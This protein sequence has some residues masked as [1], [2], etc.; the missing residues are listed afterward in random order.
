[1]YR[2]CARLMD[3][4]K[5]VGFVLKDDAGLR[6]EMVDARIVNIM[7][8][9]GQFDISCGKNGFRFNDRVRSIGDLPGVKLDRGSR[10]QGRSSRK[11][12][13]G[14]RKQGVDP[15]A[16]TSSKAPGLYAF[17]ADMDKNGNM[18]YFSYSSEYLKK[19]VES[20][21]TKKL[22]HRRIVDSILAYCSGTSKN[23]LLLSGLKG[24]GKTTAI[25]Q[26]IKYIEKYKETV[27]ISIHNMA[28]SDL[29]RL[30]FGKYVDKKYMFIDGITCIEDI[31]KKASFLKHLFNMPGRKVL[32]CGDD[33][34]ALS[35]IQ[36]ESL[37]GCEELLNMTFLDYKDSGKRL[38]QYISCESGYEHNPIYD[39]HSLQV[40]VS[41]VIISNISN[42]LNMN[43]NILKSIK[44][45]GIDYKKINGI[46][47]RLLYYIAY[48]NIAR[49]G[50]HMKITS[51]CDYMCE[52][53]N[54][55]INRLVQEQMYVREDLKICEY[56]AHLVLDMLMDMGIVDM[57][58][59][60]YNKNDSAYYITNP[61]L[62]N[63]ITKE[64]VA[65]IGI[66]KGKIDQQ[67][68][69]KIACG[70]TLENIVALHTL[71]AARRMYL[72]VS[73]YYGDSTTGVVVERRHEGMYG[74]AY[75]YYEVKM[76]PSINTKNL[77]WLSDELVN[78]RRGGLVQG[79][80]VLVGA[81]A[82]GRDIAES[83][84]EA[85]N[86]VPSGVSFVDIEEYLLNPIKFISEAMGIG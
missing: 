67:A 33:S 76:G 29:E 45:W 17:R 80:V 79:R 46:V 8:H 50:N 25:L 57:I 85:R 6:H 77:R 3:G 5:R 38:K 56:E 72:D 36:R 27:Y 14:S 81:K 24:A 43:R 48:Q 71:D 44:E 1:M 16:E 9:G 52:Q 63:Q 28:Y 73:I 86:G 31:V 84:D 34:L 49:S 2:A 4:K 23:V 59:G 62:S 60:A 39:A 13:M 65:N 21:V 78:G 19:Y 26:A 75:A 41:S 12:G 37:Y 82:Y 55:E 32:I 10:K 15:G 20:V 70:A 40:Y 22:Q 68:V 11:Q 53:G 51:V 83:R 54:K 61:I 69:E 35:Y 18:N 64:L 58:S 66:A 30:L 42:T 74:T 47:C 7:L